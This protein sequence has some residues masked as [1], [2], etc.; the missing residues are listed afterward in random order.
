MNA[1]SKY[2]LII[3][4][5]ALLALVNIDCRN[6]CRDTG[7]DSGNTNLHSDTSVLKGVSFSGQ[8]C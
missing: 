4:G 1:F 3:L 2:L 8:G 7:D 6:S 5:V